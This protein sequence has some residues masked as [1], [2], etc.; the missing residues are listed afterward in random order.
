MNTND[1]NAQEKAD[2]EAENEYLLGVEEL[3]NQN[4]Q[5]KDLQKAFNHLRRASEKG[6]FKATEEIA[7]ATLFGDYLP[8]NITAAKET[9][10]AIASTHSSPR[11]QFY[12]GFLYA[13]GLGVK[14]HQAKAL[15]YLTFAA[16]GGDHSAQMALGYRYWSGINVESSCETALIYYRK[17]ATF[18]ANQISSNSIG[19]LI[20]RTRLYDEEEKI[21]GQS[22]GMLD[23]DL[24]QYY[25][26][27]ADRG[28]AQAQYGLGL[29]YYQGAKGLNINYEKALHYFSRA[30]DSGNN[31]AMAYLGKL[32]LEGGSSIKQDNATAMRYFKMASDKSNPI[33]HA[34]LGQIYLY[35]SG[36]E[37][38]YTKA[39]KY[40]QL[41]ADQNYV[42]GHFLLG[43]MHFYGYGVKKDYKLAVKH[44]NLAAQLG[45]ILG[46]Y[47]LAQM[48]ATGTGVMRSCATATE[49]YKNVAERGVFSHKL[50]EAY[51]AYKE[52]DVD[53]ALIKYLLASEL[54][55][56]V[57]QSNAAY[58]MD[59]CKLI[60]NYRKLAIS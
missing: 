48:H 54:G 57:A 7:I 42:E 37:K 50:V 14:S 43:I 25:Q 24:V 51:T 59:Q 55:M 11:S 47:N 32:Y 58:I 38:D 18:V 10:E 23:D 15:T 20:Q 30:A 40:F 3:N 6:S 22:Q 31:Y 49:L 27:L 26:L 39:F 56:E 28:D 36:V 13:T 45:H 8:R 46:F 44:L 4:I 19:A 33:G 60:F 9:F 1:Q 41:S 16:L 29:L 35:G 5:K 53:K 21:A 2:Q 17:V 52:N 12:L 34:G